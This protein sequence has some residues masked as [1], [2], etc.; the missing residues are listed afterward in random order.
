MFKNMFFLIILFR[1]LNPRFHCEN[2][3]D[4]PPYQE[5]QSFFDDNLHYG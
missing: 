1:L 3:H 5:F 4:Q 2:H